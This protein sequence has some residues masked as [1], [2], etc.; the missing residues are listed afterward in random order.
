MVGEHLRSAAGRGYTER[1]RL[2]LACGVDPDTPGYHPIL[3][4]RSA[5]E[6]AVGNGQEPVARLLADAGA[7]SI[8]L[9]DVDRVVSV[10]GVRW[11]R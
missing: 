4:D 2:L 7:S 1:V 8:R 6:V 9:D 10:P 3:G 5:Y 11:P